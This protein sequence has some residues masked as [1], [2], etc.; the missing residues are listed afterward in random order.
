MP[1]S[2]WRPFTPKLVTVLG[3]GYSPADFRADCLAGLTVAIIALP[4]AMALGIASGTTPDKGLLTAVVAGFLISALGGSRVQIGGPT[5]AF[6][7]VVFNVIAKHGFDGLVLATLLAGVLLVIAGFARLGTWIKYIPDPVVTG[8]TTGIAVIIFSSQVRDLFGL[9]MT[10]VPADFLEKWSAFWSARMSVNPWS[11]AVSVV[12]VALI[13]FSR[14]YRPRF[15]SFL[16]TVIAGSVAVAVFGLP[17][18]T[19][20]SR[21]GAI[22]AGLPMPHV[23]A[24]SIARIRDLMP[25]ALTIAFLAGVESLLSAVVADGMTGRRHRS[26]CELV[27]QGVANMA[28]AFFG[29]IPATGAIA[30]T[31]TNVR[32]GARSPVAGML[33]AL[34]ILL[35]M[36]TLAPVMIYVPLACLAAVLVVVAWNMS[37][38]HRFRRL[39]GAP[40]GDRMVLLLTFG[41][42]VLVDLTVAIEVGVV[43]ASVLFMHRMA[44]A[45]AVEGGPVLFEENGD[46]DDEIG[47]VA[48]EDLPPGVEVFEL[49]GPLFFGASGRLLD[50][51]EATAHQPPAVFVLRMRE[52][53]LVDT[54]GESALR[55]FVRRSAALGTRV[56]ITELQPA[57][58]GLLDRMSFGG[59]HPNLAITATLTDALRAAAPA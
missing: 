51:L 26:N 37:E 11:V 12:A 3:E 29:G 52:V 17:V 34:F 28:S 36:L 25:S 50:L 43:L 23:P 18:D 45:V 21:F 42:T 5:G 16:A 8:F 58:A 53:P 46:D 2:R 41:L 56:V 15:P 4:L 13:L 32:S 38:L 1:A 9:R 31:A 14:R 10:E 6:V 30:R 39:L 54:S 49:R 24:I 55:E 7:V 40:P 47:A 57:A 19:I 22:A 44:E 20:G 27:A 59:H 35:F 48:R 33:H